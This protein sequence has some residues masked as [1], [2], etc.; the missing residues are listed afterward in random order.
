[1]SLLNNLKVGDELPDKVVQYIIAL[2]P[3]N[4]RLSR[5]YMPS[6]FEISYIST[7]YVIMNDPGYSRH[8]I[9]LLNYTCR[10]PLP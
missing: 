3:G 2:Y 10:N 5:W 1:M 9:L 7:D 8:Y 4:K 6:D